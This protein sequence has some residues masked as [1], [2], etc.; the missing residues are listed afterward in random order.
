MVLT[1]AAGDPSRVPRWFLPALSATFLLSGSSALIY[2]VLWLRLLGLVFGVTIYAASTVWASFMA[3]LA[4]GSFAAGRVADRARRPLL[5]FAGAELGIGVSAMSTPWLLRAL[6]GLFFYFSPSLNNSLATATAVRFGISFVVLALPTALMGATLPLVLKSSTLRPDRL[7]LSTAILYA[8]NTAGAIAGALAAGLYFVPMLGMTATFRSAG[9]LNL[10]AAVAAAAISR[11]LGTTL[12]SVRSA[13]PQAGATALDVGA[14]AAAR[15]VVLATFAVSG[16]VSLALEVI[17]LRVSVLILGPT[18]YVVSL[19]L[20]GVLLGIATGSYAVAP[21]LGRRRHGVA[22]LALLEGAVAFSA[23]LSIV[24]LPKVPAVVAALPAGMAALAP[25]YLV[26][27]VVASVIVAVPPML[28]MGVAF[29]LGLHVWA[30]R[31]DDPP[32][33][34]FA[35]RVAT[36]Y[37]LNVCGGIAGSLVAGFLLLPR[38]GSRATLIVVCSVTL[39]SAVAL[40]A[41]SPVRRSVRILGAFALAGS[42]VA[43]ARSVPSPV[44]SL[45]ALRHPGEPILW[46][47]EGVQTTASVQS[48]VFGRRRVLYLDGYHQADDTG[49]LTQVHH[50]I[51][52]LP[53]AVHPNPRTALVVGLGGGATA[54]AMARDAAVDVT[55]VELSDTVVRA[56][57]F[58]GNINYDVLQKPNVHLRIDDGRSFLALTHQRYDVITADAIQPIRAGSASLYSAEYFELAKHAL[59]DGGLVLQWFEGT[60][61][62][63][64]LVTRT[65]LSVFPDATLWADGSLLVGTKHRLRLDPGDFALKLEMPGFPEALQSIG[66]NRFDDLVGLFRAG[67]DD[68]RRW[69]G[70][71]PILTDDRPILEYF[72]SQPREPL[73]LKALRGDVG[74]FRVP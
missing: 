36:F 42:F 73:D 26:P 14:G 33:A 68:L 23:M 24:V 35:S 10:A 72:L 74:P 62:E 70:D 29:P 4:I 21:F 39:A 49:G 11:R 69:V 25:A 28:L 51:G 31:A 15:R 66:I 8:S 43:L 58:F 30:E 46:R 17:W 34:G 55:V 59:N 16:G 18:V 50:Q 6:Q 9:A 7:G 61:A 57:A 27:I 47:E 37:S 1:G 44:D 12:E 40:L 45:L 41:V 63:W 32:A 38:F 65:F 60:D 20:A 67:P 64:R 2:Q 71:G 22:T 13:V 3:G 52:V 5:W 54:G 56:A 48:I 19:L 53:L